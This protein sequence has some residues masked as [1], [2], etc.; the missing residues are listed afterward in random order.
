M[1]DYETSAT[2]IPAGDESSYLV[3]KTEISRPMGAELLIP[4]KSFPPG[5]EL[6]HA[7]SPQL[8]WSHYRSLMRVNNEVDHETEI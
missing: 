6:P 3:P 2:I 7:F 1:G 5:R 4:E 8:S